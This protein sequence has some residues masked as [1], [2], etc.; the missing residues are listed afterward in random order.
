MNKHTR[1][2][3]PLLL[4][5]I[6]PSTVMAESS[7][8]YIGINAATFDAKDSVS[9]EEIDGGMLNLGFDLNNYLAFEVAG[10]ASKSKDDPATSSSSKINYAAS[11]FIRFNL[12]FNRVTVYVLGG[13]SQVEGTG[14]TGTTSITVKEKGGSYGY[15]I[16]FYGT[17]DL[18][19]SLRRVELV[20]SDRATG[21][22]T[23]T[24]IN[25]G[26]TMVGITYYFDT[27][28]IRSRY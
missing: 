13:Y 4:V 1:M 16:D 15:G 25:T 10:G 26:A 24:K 21:P 2:I 27:P 18:A 14:T 3:L 20:E 8:M 6:L 23:T 9:K 7:P 22:A 19:L 11:A 5:F 17:R 12:R 28:K